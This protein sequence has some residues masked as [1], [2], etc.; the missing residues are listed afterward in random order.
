MGREWRAVCSGSLI[1]EVEAAMDP[2][3]RRR[4]VDCSGHLIHRDMFGGGGKGKTDGGEIARAGW[5]AME[6]RL[7][8]AI[9]VGHWG[10]IIHRWS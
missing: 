4:A 5:A 8:S 2:S 10:L 7:G 3:G 1:V 9:S 6:R